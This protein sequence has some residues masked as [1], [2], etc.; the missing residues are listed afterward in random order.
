MTDYAFLFVFIAIKS[1][2]ILN[3][4]YIYTRWVQNDKKTNKTK[5]KKNNIR[6]VVRCTFNAQLKTERG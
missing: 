2:A 1:T 4:L 5:V 3:G 6:Q